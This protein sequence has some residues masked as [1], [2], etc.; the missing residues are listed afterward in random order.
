MKKIRITRTLT[1]VLLYLFLGAVLVSATSIPQQLEEL[2]MDYE[3]KY[4]E[5]TQAL[6]D[7]KS[8]VVAELGRELQIAKDKYEKAKNAITPTQKTKDKIKDA[9]DK[10]KETIVDIFDIK[11]AKGTSYK[12]DGVTTLNGYADQSININ[13]N[14]YCGQF[15][16]SAVFKGLGISADPQKVY[17][18]TNPAGIFTGPST[19]VEY[20]NLNGVDAAKR[21]NA[22]IADIAN[23]ID[24]G[25]PVMLLMGTEDGTPHWVTIYG[26]EAND[27]GRITSF[28]MRD[29]YWG[30]NKGYSMDITTFTDR[31]QNPM[32]SGFAS[33]FVGY[34]NL[35]IDIK[36]TKAKD[37]SPSLTNFTFSTATEDNVAGGINDIVTGF[38]NI[39]PVRFVA[40]TTKC[41]LGIPGAAVGIVSKGV[42]A[43]GDKL[44]NW[45]KDNLK[46]KDGV[47]NKILNAATATVA[48]GVK[49][50]AAVGEVAGN[51]LSGAANMAGNFIN[52]LGY[53]FK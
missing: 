39:D 10:I 36:G 15:A 4:K 3:K 38:K 17:K 7:G 18:E 27:Q 29:S 52:K 11:D 24:Q 20:L 23:R 26:Y 25:L 41:V 53:V 21:N 42:S 8:S 19:I 34:S 32:G 31:W 33:N 9:K 43:L 45:R 51:I 22:T 14:N 47:G 1:M 28:T 46:G 13:G 16:M 30:T 37:K 48:V 2:K 40:G 5:Y 35:M 12:E 6:S 44:N 50:V 49:A